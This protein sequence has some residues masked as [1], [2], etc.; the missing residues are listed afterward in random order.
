M[1]MIV[2]NEIVSYTAG[3]EYDTKP[4]IL[5]LDLFWRAKP[6]P[7]QMIIPEGEVEERPV[8]N[9]VGG[10][11]NFSV[12]ETVEEVMTAINNALNPV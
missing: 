5:N 3:G 11:N 4:T 9:I 1:A 12:E 7:N 8:T 2:L 10:G 6:S